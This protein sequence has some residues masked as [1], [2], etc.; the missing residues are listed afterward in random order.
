MLLATAMLVVAAPSAHATAS[1]IVKLHCDLSHTSQDDP[2]VFPGQPGAA[3]IHN[4]Y[5]NTTTDAFSTTASLSGGPTTC[6]TVGDNAAY[7]VPQAYLNGRP[8][9]A[10]NVAEYWRNESRA[11]VNAPPTGMQFVAHD[12]KWGCTNGADGTPLPQPC[13]T[14][15]GNV[16]AKVF[17]PDC[18]RG[19]VF[20]YDR[21]C[22]GGEPIAQL[23]LNVNYHITDPTGMTLS[24]KDPVTGVV[25]NDGSP[26]T[27]HA[28]FFNAWDPQAF[29]RVVMAKF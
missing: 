2:I 5:G 4:F 11:V 28:D 15:Q 17:F 18:L 1:V 10:P 8:L 6:D 7:W 3:H 13:T 16:K 20:S 29:A 22:A 9:P 14:A 21:D 12:F 19:T 27:M 25:T 23:Q 24:V 26:S